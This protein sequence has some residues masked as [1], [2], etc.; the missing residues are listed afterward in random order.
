MPITAKLNSIVPAV[1]TFF[2][3]LKEVEYNSSCSPQRLSTHCSGAKVWRNYDLERS[4]WL[5]FIFI[6]IWIQDARL[7]YFQILETQGS[8]ARH[9]VFC[10]RRVYKHQ[11]STCS[12]DMSGCIVSCWMLLCAKATAPDLG[13]RL[14]D[15][16]WVFVFCRAVP[17]SVEHQMANSTS[18]ASSHRTSDRS[19][20]PQGAKKGAMAVPCFEK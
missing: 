7:F 4:G 17:D 12:L 2:N 19:R 9:S 10:R 13:P 11:A 20:S 6:L 18:A 16:T 5:S 15:S 1:P 14:R 8:G 3:C